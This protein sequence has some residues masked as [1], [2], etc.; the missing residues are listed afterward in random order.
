M[1][2]V[3]TPRGGRRVRPG[4]EETGPAASDRLGTVEHCSCGLAGLVT[5]VGAGAL[6]YPTLVALTSHLHL[7]SSTALVALLV[8]TWLACWLGFE[9]AWEWRARRLSTDG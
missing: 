4:R 5:A 7:L 8:G 3:Y 9:L 2:R 1:V 6:L